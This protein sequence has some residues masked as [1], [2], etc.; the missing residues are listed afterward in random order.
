MALHNSSVQHYATS[1]AL[2]AAHASFIASRKVL[3][4]ASAQEI[5]ASL[6]NEIPQL[7]GGGGN[8]EFEV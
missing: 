1:V 8:V 6:A 4:A 5:Q 3:V 2:A 7:E